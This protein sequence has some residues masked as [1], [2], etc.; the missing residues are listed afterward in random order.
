MYMLAHIKG[1][2]PKYTESEAGTYGVVVTKTTEDAAGFN[3]SKM[4][5]RFLA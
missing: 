5:S 2:G 1:Q 3:V 4:P